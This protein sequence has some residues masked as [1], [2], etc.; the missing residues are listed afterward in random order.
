MTIAALHKLTATLAAV[1]LSFGF[2]PISSQAPTD[3]ASGTPPQRTA[4][5]SEGVLRQTALHTVVPAYPDSSIRDRV[6]GVSVVEVEISP[7]GI[8]LDVRLLEA[9]D[10]AI[11]EATAHAVRQW[12]FPAASLQG[13]ST[14]VRLIGKLTF[15]FLISDRVGVVRAPA[16]GSFL[17][18]RPSRKQTRRP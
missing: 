1:A 4:R 7:S 11:G 12:K 6:Q 2:T 16:S 10:K 18:Q 5:T 13:S 3:G 9:P 17:V 8:L 15:Y 14:P